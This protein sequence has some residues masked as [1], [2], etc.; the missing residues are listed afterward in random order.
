MSK[1]IKPI[2]RLSTLALAVG[3]ANTGYANGL[4][5]VVVTAQKREQGIQD[6]PVAVTAMTGEQLQEEV[7]KDVFDLQTSVPGLS[8]GM[9]QQA[10]TASFSIRGIGT[11]GQNYGLE[12]SVG[13]YVDG[14]YRSRQSAM[15]NDM[16]DME[17]VEVLRGPQG[18]LFGKNTPSGAI[19]FR[20]KAPD[21]E[22]S[23]Y[24]MANIGDYNLQTYQFGKSITLIDDT[25]AMR[26]TGF[27]SERDGFGK[28]ANLDE[29]LNNRNRWGLRFQV[30]W[31]P[32]DDL[33]ARFIADY[34]KINEQCC[35]A[36]TLISNMVASG[37]TDANGGPVY[38]T[39]AILAQLGGT[40]ASG[41]NYYD[42]EMYANF[43]PNGQLE[44]SGYSLEVNWDL[45]DAM[46]LTS[47]TS[48]R[49]FD[50]RDEVDADFSDVEL[51]RA[52]NDPSIESFS[53]EIRLNY[54]SDNF[55]AVGG[56]YYF[57]QT[58]DLHYELNSHPMLQHFGNVALGLGDLISPMNDINAALTGMGL[59]MLFPAPANPFF[60]EYGAHHDAKQDQKSYALFGQTD[61]NLSDNWVLTL[62]ARFTSEEKKLST[63]YY[64]FADGNSAMLGPAISMADLSTSNPNGVPAALGQLAYALGYAAQT[65]DLSQAQAYLTDPAFMGQFAPF[66]TQ[67]W[68]YHLLTVLAPRPDI[69]ASLDDEQ[70]TGNIK[71]SYTPN[72]ST[73]IYAS[74]ATG[75]KSGGTNTD[76][77]DT[78]FDPVFDAET[79][80]TY[81]VGMK[82]DFDDYGLRINAAI[83]STVV[84]DF[85]TNTFTG[86]GFNL[87]NAGQLE[88]MG[89][90]AEITWAMSETFVMQ[91]NYAYNDAT[92]KSFEQGNCWVG[93]TWHT[94]MADPGLN[95]DGVS[96]NRTGD[97]LSGVPKHDVMFGLNKS[98]YISSG[99]EAFVAGEYI[100]RSDQM[101]DGNNDPYKMQDSIGTYNARAGL[102]FEDS[103]ID[104]VLWGRNITDEEFH[105]TVFDASLQTGR[106][107]AY[108]GEPST[109]GMSVSMQF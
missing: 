53:Q 26:I 45:S 39:D 33:S 79:S 38:G 37:R 17:A 76:R 11:S 25:A 7:I 99:I 94:G 74:A 3:L 85:Q 18:T 80:T 12:S 42:R 4:E 23:G 9:N 93:Y 95:A 73:L 92:F 48:S 78:A 63:S 41:D 90:E 62:G 32:T 54:A 40:V 2:L 14:V 72:D 49:S 35:V 27:S 46:S 82:K 56:L 77:I 20:T 58:V 100:Y 105:Y 44:D 75:Y 69:E 10:N 70:V 21:Y 5:E 83:F 71:L 61:F 55:N 43:A 84:D 96:C 36:P 29:D 8:A 57:D 28:V 22:G 16:I 65:G 66:Q 104:L 68:G 97:R 102:R 6:V 88:A 30:L 15:I 31:E 103:G 34:A 60:D 107:N 47:V 87:Q 108:P 89:G 19:L 98:F 86:T 91:L 1:N 106:M 101:M 13:L 59:G 24:V 109:F 64:E 67:G 50:T 52:V 81:E 51:I